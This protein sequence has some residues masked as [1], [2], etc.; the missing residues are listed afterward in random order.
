[1]G[2]GAGNEGVYVLNELINRLLI[3]YYTL[4]LSIQI[5]HW[6]GHGVLVTTHQTQC[7]CSDGVF[8]WGGSGMGW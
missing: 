2:I 1:M 6:S 8:I 5:S 7:S 3:N 4:N